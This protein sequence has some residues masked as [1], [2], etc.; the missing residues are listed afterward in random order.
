[1]QSWSD[2]IDDGVAAILGYHK[3]GEPSDGNYPSWNYISA[4]GF[5]DQLA[6]LRREGWSGVGLQQ[7]L[8]ALSGR[9][10]LPP[11]SALVTFDDGY[12]STL[13]EALPVLNAFGFPAVV[14]VPTDYVGGRNTFDR[15]I[16]PEEPMC[17]WDELRNLHA[18]GV[19][20]Q[21]HGVSHTSLSS[22]EEP[23]MVHEL[24]ESKSRLQSELGV[25]VEA[26]A[27]PYGDDVHPSL[28]DDLMQKLGYAVAFRYGGGLFSKGKAAFVSPFRIPRLAM[29]PDTDLAA[30]LNE[31]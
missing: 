8:A 5:A 6:V 11:K 19:S 20:V 15:G 1:M 27:Y 9:E 13:T 2:G 4:Q 18:S 26:F 30:L 21:A 10:P 24:V 3:I 12:R 29:G 31:T 16:E 28:T 22:L 7:F 23:A 25:S 14:F 17:T